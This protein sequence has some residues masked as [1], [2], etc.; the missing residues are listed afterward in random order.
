[1]SAPEVRDGDHRDSFVFT[2]VEHIARSGAK[3][4]TLRSDVSLADLQG[5]IFDLLDLARSASMVGEV[6]ASFGS[7]AQRSAWCPRLAK[8]E[9]PA[10]VENCPAECAAAPV[11]AAA[12][13][14]QGGTCTASASGATDARKRS[15]SPS[16]ASRPCGVR[17]WPTSSSTRVCGKSKPSSRRA[18]SPATHRLATSASLQNVDRLRML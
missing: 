9:L 5:E 6:I 15:R 14:G 17:P 3:V 12:A 4:C 13:A 1:M 18:A 2:L 7:D 10:C 11:P 16:A 8:G